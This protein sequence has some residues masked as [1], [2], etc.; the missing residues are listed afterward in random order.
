MR[1]SEIGAGHGG[2]KLGCG[3]RHRSTAD[4]SQQHPRGDR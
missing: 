1:R 3:I 2:D 4:D